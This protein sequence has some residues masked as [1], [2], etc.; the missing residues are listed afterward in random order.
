MARRYKLSSGSPEPKDLGL[1]PPTHRQILISLLPLLW[2][3][4]DKSLRVRVVLAVI[5]LLGAKAATVYVPFIYKDAVDALTQDEVRAAIAVVPIFLILAYGVGRVMM[6]GL[7]QLRDAL[8]APVGQRAVRHLAIATFRHL[9]ALSLR[10]HLERRTGGLSRIIERG[11]KAIDFLLR[12]VLFN[13]VPTLFELILV[14]AILG[15]TFDVWYAVVVGVMVALYV[16]FTFAVTEWRTR[17]RREMNDSDTTANT[18]AVDSLLNYETVKY[19]GNEEHE[20]RRFDQSLATYENAAVRT[21]TSLSLFNAGQ[22]IIFTVGLAGLML[23]AGRGVAAGTMTVGDFVL[24]NAMLIQL[25]QPLNMLGTVYREI[26]QAL[27]DMETMLTLMAVPPEVVD[28]P[29][30]KP[31]ALAGGEVRFENVVFSYDPD[32]RILHGVD[33]AIPAGRTVAVVGASGAGKSTLSRLLYRFYDVDE[34]RILIDGQNIA[35]VTQDS[36]RA[37]IGM[38]PQDTVLFNDTIRY[39]IRYGRPKAS[40]VEVEE[41]AR[42]AQIAGFIE[43]LPSG[44]ETLVGERGLKLS[45]GEKQRVAIARTILKNPPILVLDEATSALDSH[46]EAEIQSALKRVSADRTTLIVAHRLSTIVDAD[47]ILVMDHGE[48]VERGHHAD[49][50][51]AGGRYA[52]MWTRQQ[53]ADRLRLDEEGDEMDAAGSKERAFGPV[54]A[55][56]NSM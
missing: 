31:L 9:H 12:F 34:G 52:A 44:F 1:S 5:A 8:F 39:N 6:V 43:R 49:L 26:K 3:T 4:E 47:E 37:A 27:I 18:R 15:W 55:R 13:I 36:L 56:A 51:A 10:F 54:Q 32:R 28:R 50:L 14:C 40:D 38:V 11:T 7:A 19:F 17:F 2:P 45:G 53:Q 16:A 30:A 29:G 23:M 33:F 41:A 35:E 22:A 48:I 46:T 25:Y 21:T 42:L 20:A 24:V